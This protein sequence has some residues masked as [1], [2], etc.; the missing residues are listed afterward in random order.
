M[1]RALEGNAVRSPIAALIDMKLVACGPGEAVMEAYPGVQHVN[2][3][4]IVHGGFAATV[5]DAAIWSAVQ[6][7][8]PP[9]ETVTTLELKVSYARA[10]TPAT[11]PVRAT[12]RLI[13]RGGRIALAEGDLRDKD[14]KIL[15]HATSTLMVLK[16]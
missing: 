13:N 4:N 5:L 6:T 12:G 14:G 11:G 3:I 16:A 8:S 7:T 1:Q 9:G 2:P 10:M 15:A